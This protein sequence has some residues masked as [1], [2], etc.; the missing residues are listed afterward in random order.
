MTKVVIWVVVVAFVGTIIFA[1]GMDIG[2][3]KAQKNIVGTVNGQDF[4]WRMYQPGYERLY[5]AEQAK[6]DGELSSSTLR[7]IRRQAWDNLVSDYLLSLEIEKR[8]IAISDADLVSFLRFQPPPELQQNPSFQTDGKFD[9]QKYMGAMADPNPQSV[10]FWAR[11]EAIY[12]P[13]LSRSKLQQQ[14]MSTVRVGEQEL[15]DYFINSWEKV[16]VDVISVA[17]SKYVNPGPEVSDEDIADYFARH[18]DD[19]QVEDRASL[20]CVIFS[21]DPTEEDW[22]RIRS[23]ADYVKSKIDEGDD[24][25]ELAKSYSED[26]SAKNGGD[27]GW[28]GKG[29]MVPEFEETAFGLEKGQVSDP[30]R[31]Q[32]G[33]H[34]IKKVGTK[35]D[36]NGEQVQASHILFK[37]KAS[38]ET[39]DGAFQNGNDLLDNLSGSD[40]AGVAEKMEMEVVNTGLFAKGANIPNI[41][42]DERINNFAFNNEIGDVSQVFETDAAVIIVKVAEHVPPGVAS[43]EEV[44]DRVK[45]DLIEYLAMEKCRQDIGEVYARIQEGVDFNKAAE[46]AG[47]ETRK[48]AALTRNSFI[49]GVGRDPAMVGAIFALTNPG[50]MTEPV[51]YDRGYAIARMNEI[52]GADLSIYGKV[53]DSLEQDLLNTKQREIFNVWYQDM[54]ESAEVVDYLSEL[55]TLR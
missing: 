24:F 32:F 28:F 54:I 14:I 6:G 15:R 47:L 7:R 12:R 51:K 49:S 23:D 46:E 44:K 19:Y 42:L 9:Y 38:S 45:R 3:S 16:D 41:G 1:W 35:T 39:I 40:L 2:R 29:R 10:A 11:V 30:V 37:I 5:Q 17:S 55:F 21:K 25:A 4:E 18:Q 22:E 26:G 36:D 52:I 20:D 34:I 53:R 50:D 31:T 43:L 33:W 8:Q 27:L 13:Q 48:T